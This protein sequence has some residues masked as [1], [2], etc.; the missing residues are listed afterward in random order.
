MLYNAGE[1]QNI[2][3]KLYLF[4]DMSKQ[5]RSQSKATPVHGK[6]FESE[7]TFVLA[8]FKLLVLSV[9]MYIYELYI[10]VISVTVT[11]LSTSLSL[12]FSYNCVWV[13][14][15]FYCTMY[16]FVGVVVWDW[17][18]YVVHHCRLS[19]VF[20]CMLFTLTALLV[21]IKVRCIQAVIIII[22]R[23]QILLNLSLLLP[24]WQ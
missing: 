6:K 11:Y 7:F 8:Q 15:I 20:M 5:Q 21:C 14:V 12:S 3:R 22:T 18:M 1:T 16:V 4:L 19:F 24:N 17:M 23:N 2:N 10:W 13:K 9:L